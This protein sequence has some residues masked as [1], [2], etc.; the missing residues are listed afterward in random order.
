VLVVTGSNMS[1]KSTLLRAIGL[2]VVL[3]QMGAPVCAR[4]MSVP[5]T[6]LE[7]S[8]RVADSLADGVSYFMAALLRLKQIV[9]AADEPWHVGQPR[10]LYLLDEVLQGTNSDERQIAIRHI[11]RHL[12]ASS[13]IGALTTHDLH[14]VHT[15]EFHAHARHVHFTEHVEPGAD[16]PVMH[17]DY[18]L[19]AGP[20]Q[21]R[22][23]LALVRMVGL[24]DAALPEP[25]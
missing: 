20:A 18:V 4:S 10:V 17:F 11:V 21:S 15:P 23:A 13:A 19:R 12:V 1:G 5:S 8:I 14:L 22:N 25:S 9:S 24:G 16:P 7:T 6:R 2:N 3:A